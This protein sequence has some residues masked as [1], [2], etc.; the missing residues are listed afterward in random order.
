MIDIDHHLCPKGAVVMA[1]ATQIQQVLMNLCINARH[2]M[3]R[4]GGLLTVRLANVDLDEKA[5][6]EVCPVLIP[7]P[8]VEIVVE[9][10]G[11]GMDDVTVERIFEPFFTTKKPGE[12]SGMG[13]AV[14]HGIVTDH[15]GAISVSTS[16]GKGS[17][18]RVLLPRLPE[19][20]L[21]EKPNKR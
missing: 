7:G 3:R 8:Y 12:G 21:M 5:A 10:T 15:A 19:S 4:K 20:A 14:V 17:S 1:D 9:D 16:P 11:E 6:A 13:L 18:F 2:A